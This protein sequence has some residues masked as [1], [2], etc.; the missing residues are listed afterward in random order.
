MDLKRVKDL[1][2]AALIYFYK[3]KEVPHDDAVL[4][5]IIK[6]VEFIYDCA[7]KELDPRKN[8]PKGKAFTYGVL[9]SKNFTSPE[10]L[11]LKEQLN[12]LDDELFKD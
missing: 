10:E 7:S 11:K 4:E 5:S 12:N 9:S 6:Q 3:Q 2:K 8:L 1:A